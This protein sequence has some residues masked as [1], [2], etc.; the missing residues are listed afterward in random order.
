MRGF[1]CFGLISKGVAVSDRELC[2]VTEMA[3]ALAQVFRPIRVL[4]HLAWPSHVRE[5][6]F[7]LKGKALPEVTYP[8]FNANDTLEKTQNLRARLDT[9]NPIDRWL[10]KQTDIVDQTAL[11]LSHCGQKTFYR[12]SQALYGSP[13]TP[14]LDGMSTSLA[15]A[16]HF[17]AGF[18]E[19]QGIDLGAPAPACHLAHSVAETLEQHC[20][21]LFAQAAPP[22]QIVDELSANALAGAKRVRIRKTACFSD[23]DAAQLA[24]HEVGVHVLTSLNG[25]A[26]TQ[27]P[28]LSVSHPGTTKTQEGLAVFA[29]FITGSIDLERIRRLADRVIAIH[30]AE[31]GADFLQVFDYFCARTD[32]Y[33]AFENTRRVFRG[34]VLTGGAPFTKDIVYLDGFLHVHT[35]LQQSLALK[36]PEMMRMLFLGKLD[37][38][39][40]PVLMTL[41]QKG[42]LSEPKYLPEWAADLRFLLSYLLSSR[43][44]NGI[45]LSQLTHRY[46]SILSPLSGL[47][48]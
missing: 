13:N 45:D 47:K 22:V 17:D 14:V 36:S 6:F 18:D 29:E 23:K 26:Q 40:L 12:H 34:G 7:R 35:F 4:G 42:L 41:Q 5:R 27:F 25:Q 46:R 44:M 2:R 39:D 30:M 48:V 8:E 1:W 33:Q 38:E 19:L 21:K 43:F 24:H 31:Q 11:M 15:L 16:E 28:W 20:Q 37:L 32:Q 3:I 10:L 9:Q